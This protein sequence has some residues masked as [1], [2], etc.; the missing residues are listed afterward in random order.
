MIKH[1]EIIEISTIL[2]LDRETK[3]ENI[4]A[5]ERVT[6]TEQIIEIQNDKIQ[7]L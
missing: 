2:K 1:K 5:I 4:I 6:I 3:K 7:R